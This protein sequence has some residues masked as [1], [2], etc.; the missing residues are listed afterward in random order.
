MAA[1]GRIIQA[2][3]AGNSM[4]LGVDLG[5]NYMAWGV[6]DV[7][8]SYLTS[9]HMDIIRGQDNHETSWL[10]MQNFWQDQPEYALVVNETPYIDH[11]RPMVYGSQRILEHDLICWGR[12]AHPQLPFHSISRAEIL[13]AFR[14]NTKC[15][16]EDVIERVR[17]YGLGNPQS[18][19]EADAIAAA[20]VGRHFAI[21]ACM[22]RGIVL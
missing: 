7:H 14:L 17:M 11:S 16:K 18:E 13:S 20:F 4:I 1:S 15:S 19:H 8:G 22:K 3:K 12:K 9:S 5:I 6:V 21:D 2:I 10:T